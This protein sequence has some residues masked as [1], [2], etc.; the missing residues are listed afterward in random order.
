MG[1]EDDPLSAVVEATLARVAAQ[2]EAEDQLNRRRLALW[3]MHHEQKQSVGDIAIH[4]REALLKHLTPA[5][6]KDLG[7]GYESIAKIVK[8]PKPTV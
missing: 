7:V 4:V 2:M 1:D 5:Q 6:L 8:G 3:R